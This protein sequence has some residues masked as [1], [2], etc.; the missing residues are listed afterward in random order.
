MNYRNYRN[1][2]QNIVK[3]SHFAAKIRK[4]LG[5]GF[6]FRV[7]IRFTCDSYIYVFA[8]AVHGIL[9]YSDVIPVIP[10]IPVFPYTPIK[11]SIYR[12]AL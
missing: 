3:Y 4:T 9:R 7:L 11:V 6:R 8:Y 12:Q 10:V 5:L 1:L 2:R